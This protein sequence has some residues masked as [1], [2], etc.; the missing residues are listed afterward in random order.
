MEKKYWIVTDG[1][2]R[3]MPCGVEMVDTDEELIIVH[4][5]TEERALIIAASY[6][7]G[8]VDYDN[9]A[10]A[11]HGTHAAIQDVL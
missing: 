10:C 9:V 3:E 1:D 7:R 11:V 6:D 5:A 8:D 4:A 2:A